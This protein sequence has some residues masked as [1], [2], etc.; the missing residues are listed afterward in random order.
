ML[1]YK[2]GKLVR[3]KSK[4]KFKL[5]SYISVQ[6]QIAF[7]KQDRHVIKSTHLLFQELSMDN[8]EIK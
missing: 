7:A 5:I 6:Q 8:T 2:V 4:C 1:W 3:N